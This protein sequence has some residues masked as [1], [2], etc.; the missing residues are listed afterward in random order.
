MTAPKAPLW[1]RTLFTIG[2]TQMAHRPPLPRRWI[3]YCVVAYIAP[4][5]ALEALP[6]SLGT[7]REISWLITLAPAFILSLHYGMLGALAGL[8][9]GT[10]LYV[11][12]QVV[13]NINL[14]DVHQDVLLPIYVSYGMLAIAVGWLSQ[15]LHDYY[16]RLVRAERLAAIGEV[17]ITLRHELNNALQA[18]TAEAGVLRTGDLPAQ[19]IASI[20][21]I[22]DMAHR[23]QQDVHR[24]A[25]LTDVTTTEYLEGQQMVDLSA[26]PNSPPQPA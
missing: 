22:L 19:D 3:V 6:D 23:I 8:I 18:I 24:L 9:A 1:S 4:I 7:M 26:A 25:T 20:D 21:T 13:L 5:I 12:V 10:L 2:F 14:V 11:A 15:Q 16:S 17:A